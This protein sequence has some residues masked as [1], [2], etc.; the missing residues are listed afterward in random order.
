MKYRQKFAQIPEKLYIYKKHILYLS[1]CK[2]P[3]PTVTK[4]NR[5]MK[6]NSKTQHNRNNPL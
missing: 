1:N 3:C 6:T 4:L 2:K 5:S